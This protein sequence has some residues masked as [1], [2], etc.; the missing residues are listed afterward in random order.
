M[1][2]NLGC[3][4]E[5]K[6]DLEDAVRCYAEALMIK[7]GLTEAYMNLSRISKRVEEPSHGCELLSQAT[8]FG[9]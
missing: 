8:P 7:P 1:R 6:G 9:Y 4:F 2:N 3:A 5:I